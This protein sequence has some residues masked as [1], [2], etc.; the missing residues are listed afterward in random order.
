M[1]YSGWPIRREDIDPYMDKTLSI[2]NI[3]EENRRGQIASHQK[4]VDKVEKLQDF[5]GADF[6]WSRPA[7]RIGEKYKE[8]IE[9][10]ENITC[11]L[12]ANLT[13]IKLVENL[14]SVQQIEVHNYN[15]SVYNLTAENFILAAGGIENPRILLNCDRQIKAGIGNQNGNVGRFFCEHP[16]HKV[17]DFILED[18]SKA[19]IKDIWTE[20]FKDKFFQFFA[21]SEQFMKREEV[22]EFRT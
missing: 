5:K 13:D 6:W 16:H 1:N 10:A 11:F 12:N 14:N 4:F 2:L 22:M 8:Q 15:G 21:P 7:T 17:A 3:S 19:M 20:D 18:S 9:N